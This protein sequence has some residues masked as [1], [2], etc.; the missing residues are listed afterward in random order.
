MKSIRSTFRHI[1]V[2]LALAIAAPV[3]AQLTIVSSANNAQ[4]NTIRNDLDLSWLTANQVSF[5]AGGIEFT[6][7]PNYFLGD[8]VVGSGAFG[9]FYAEVSFLKR[10]SLRP[11]HFGVSTAE[12]GFGAPDSTTLLLDF[13]DSGVGLTHTLTA[14]SYTTTDFWH[15]RG[16]AGD[17]VNVFYDNV[18]FFRTW[19]YTDTVNNLIYTI[20][21]VDDTAPGSPFGDDQDFN[22]R[23]VLVIRNAEGIAINDPEPTPVPEPSTYGLIGAGVLLSFA[24]YRRFR[25]SRA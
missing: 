9:S 4:V 8:I 6:Q 25:A 16:S 17:Q 3:F 10:D 12:G 21:G 2:F 18:S 19:E 13:D 7:T 15:Y 14:A 20:L 23:T 11:N 1:G 5:T 22:D 24:A